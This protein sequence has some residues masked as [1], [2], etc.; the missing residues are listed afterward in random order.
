MNA[1][2][3]SPFDLI[4]RSAKINAE[5]HA[6]QLNI[7]TGRDGVDAQ[8]LTA[9]AK[10]DHPDDK[11]SLAIDSSALGGMYAGAIRLVGTEAGVGVKLT[12]DMAAI[13]GDIRIEADGRLGL[14]RTAAK[15]DIKLNAAQIDLTQ[16]I[17]SQQ[18]AKNHRPK[19]SHYCK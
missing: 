11:P 18:S 4:T 15:G 6:N 7:I 5:L 13:A 12:G 3:V 14:V 19:W 1:T 17:Y 9:T 8:T 16:D 10:A 2:N